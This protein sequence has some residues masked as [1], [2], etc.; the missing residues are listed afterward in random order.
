M[1]S[2]MWE[3]LQLW[4]TGRP[5][6]PLPYGK[7]PLQDPQAARGEWMWDQGWAKGVVPETKGESRR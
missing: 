7:N 5:W 6:A 4:G 3:Q 1:P 2:L